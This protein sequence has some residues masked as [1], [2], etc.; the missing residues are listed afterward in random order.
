MQPRTVSLEA[1]LT[2][3]KTAIWFQFL[4]NL[5]IWTFPTKLL[6]CYCLTENSYYQ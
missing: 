1:L 4:V 2:I 6:L 3:A 5:H